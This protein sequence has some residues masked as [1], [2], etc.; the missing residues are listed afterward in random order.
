[1]TPERWKQIEELYHAAREQG[2]AV[3]ESAD[4]ALRLEVEKLLA[5]DEVGKVLDRPAAELL[6]D[7]TATDGEFLATRPSLIGHCLGQYEV[8]ELLGAGGMGVVYKARDA[9]LNRLVALKFLPPEYRDYPELRQRLAEEAQA[10]SALDHPNIVV[11]HDIQDSSDGFFIAMAYHEGETLRERMKRPLALRE[12]LGI[13]RQMAA[14]LARAHQSGIV[15]RDIKPANVMV[16]RDGVVRIIDFGLARSAGGTTGAARGTPLYMSPEQATGQ[17]VDARTDLWSLGVVLYEMFA[18][19][20]PFRGD[21]LAQIAGAVLHRDPAPLSTLRPDLP[22]GLAA[23]VMR[24]LEKDAGKRWESAAAMERELAKIQA[25]LEAPAA[26]RLRGSHAVAGVILLLLAAI[27]LLFWQRSRRQLTAREE[28]LPAVTR[29]VSQRKMAAAMQAYRQAEAILT[30]G[31]PQ[32]KQLASGLTYEAKVTA[33]PGAMVSI[34]DFLSPDDPWIPLGVAP[35]DK[36]RLPAGYLRW[37][38]TKPGMPEYEAAP[39]LKGL[40]GFYPE[41][42]LP[43]EANAEAPSGMTVIPAAR[44]EDYIWSIGAVGPYDLPAYSLDRLEVTNRQYQQFVDGGGYS[45]R[46]FWKHPFHKDGREIPWETAMELLRDGTGRSGPSTW[47]GGRYVEGT[48]D[49][50][51]GGVSWYEAAAYA[52]YAGKSLPTLAQWYR[53][54][55]SSVSDFITVLSNFS[56]QPAP[57]GQYRGMGAYGTY[58]MAGNVT[59]WCWNGAGGGTRFALGGAY[60]T[61]SNEYFEPFA[62]APFHRAANCGFRC[63]R[64]TEPQPPAT[65]GEYR[66]TIQDFSRAKPASDEIFAIYRNLYSYA[67][68]PLHPVVERMPVESRDWR[69]EKIVVDAAY[70]RERLPLYLLLPERV[71]APYQTVIYFPTARAAASQHSEQLEDM[72]FLDFVLQSGRAVVYPVYKGTYERAAAPPGGD[73]VASR[74]TMIQASKDMRRAI[75]YLETRPEIDS[76]RLAFLGVSMGAAVGVVLTAL[77]PR[78]KTAIFLDGGFMV[79]KPVPGGDQADFAPRLKAP[80]LLVA[81]RFD[82]IFQ[83]KDALLNLI[84]APKEHKKVVMF[85]TAHDVSEQRGDLIREVLAWLDKYL[86]RVEATTAAK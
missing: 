68:A 12:G 47:R 70:G 85:D 44:Y 75:D 7:F 8:L 83:G 46:R 79:E 55:P 14:G 60:N 77:E 74:D 5:Q 86:G 27:S 3:L 45:Q 21:N 6:G 41:V 25:G 48:A 54:A 67:P 31:D 59:E 15:H 82:W 13:A 32:V 66:F 76:R 61:P 42:S 62:Y 72:H 58:D 16:A 17:A 50:P 49:Y 29:L 69:R 22:A 39:A 78:L 28:L 53:A 36:V 26:P 4:P 64:N 73:S 18:G 33:S 56:G 38:V 23:L 65:T 63:V 81:G 35:L 40:F 9:K 71:R 80:T 51:V 57:V 24:A 20:S 30:A 37:R 11:I 19:E 10:A 84:G 1:M 34:K 52:E 2:P 43:S